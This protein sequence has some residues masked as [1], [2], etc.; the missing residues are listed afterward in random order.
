LFIP[1]AEDDIEIRPRVV[2]VRAGLRELGWVEGTNIELVFRWA[3][4][5]PDRIRA[6]AAELV[7]MQPDVILASTTPTVAALVR[8]NRDIPTVFVMVVDPVGQG[9][10]QSLSKPGGNFTGFTH[11]EFGMGGKWLELLKD[12]APRLSKI[13]VIFNPD[14]APYYNSF[15]DASRSASSSSSFE[16]IALPARDPAELVRDIAAFA[17]GPN[18]G[19]LVLPDTFTTINREIIVSLAARHHLPTI[20]PLSQFTAQ[21]G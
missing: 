17:Q 1:W 16:P 10:V 6:Y 20:Y 13:A 14:T 11:F 12:A 4:G 21:A 7:A 8:S 5:S 19:L 3:A 18:G 15:I 9:L 2:A